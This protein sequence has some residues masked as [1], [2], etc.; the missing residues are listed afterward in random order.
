MTG[1]FCPAVMAAP[2]TSYDLNS[3][4]LSLTGIVLLRV[5]M[6]IFG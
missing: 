3:L 4:L 6:S 2:E 5:N 1:G